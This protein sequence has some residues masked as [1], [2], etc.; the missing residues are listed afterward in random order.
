MSCEIEHYCPNC[1]RSFPVGLEKEL[2]AARAVVVWAEDVHRFA[3]DDCGG[4]PGCQTRWNKGAELLA[5]YDKVRGKGP[6]NA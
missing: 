4:C 3:H 5:A 6:S 1:G 2:E